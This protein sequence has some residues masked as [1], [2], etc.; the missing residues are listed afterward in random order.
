MKAIICI[1]GLTNIK[2]KD[3]LFLP[4]KPN[5]IDY[6][7]FSLSQKKTPKVL[8]IGTAS[9]ERRDYYES[10]RIAYES[11]GGSVNSLDI[12]NNN[13]S[14]NEIR[15]KI[16][17]SDII[18]VGCGKT[19]FMLDIWKQKGIDKILIEA[20]KKEVILAGMSAGSY[21]WFKYN[22]ELIEGLGLIPMINCVHY[23]EKSDEKKKEFL[24]NIKQYKLDGLAIDN[25][26]AVAFID[27]KCKII[28][29]NNKLNAYRISFKDDNYIQE[30]L[31]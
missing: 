20:Y 24:K 8:F 25:D 19:K 26:V 5:K 16:L 13:L 3:N 30:I 1:G 31:K 2:S 6:E 11:L 27:Q 21:C 22:Y 7:I 4:Y 9:K 18:Y 28:Q 12:L 14:I 23:D 17:V 29:H 10:F 15:S